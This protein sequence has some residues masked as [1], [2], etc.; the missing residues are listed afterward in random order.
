MKIRNK[1]LGVIIMLVTSLC[2][3]SAQEVSVGIKFLSAT[4]E[5]EEYFD[6]PVQ[7]T[8]GTWHAIEKI[9]SEITLS[10]SDNKYSLVKYSLVL[11]RGTTTEQS[12][13]EQTNPKIELKGL[14]KSG[15]YTVELSNVVLSY[16]DKDTT[17]EVTLYDEE[18]FQV[19]N[20]KLELYDAP[21]ISEENISELSKEVVWNTTKRDFSVTANDGNESGWKYVWYIDG[22]KQSVTNNEWSGTFSVNNSKPQVFKVEVINMAPD[23][24]T[25]WYHNEYERE[26]TVYQI[27]TAEL[28][29][30]GS[31]CPQTMDWYCEDKNVGSISVRT[32]G[33]SS[34]WDYKWKYNGRDYSGETFK[35]TLANSAIS[36]GY[37]SPYEYTLVLANKPEGMSDVLVKEGE[38]ELKGSIR[39]WKTPKVEFDNTEYK[40]VF[41]GK[42]VKMT[43]NS[44][45][46]Y[47]NGW[48]I[49][50][51]DINLSVNNNTYTFKATDVNQTSEDKQFTIKYTNTLQGSYSS[52]SGTTDITVKIWN[53]PRIE[54]YYMS[55]NSEISGDRK[56]PKGNNVY[57]NSGFGGTVKLGVMLRDG[58]NDSWTYSWKKDQQNYDESESECE[59]N[60]TGIAK[61]EYSITVTNKPEGVK[62]AFTATQTF[63]LN[64]LESPSYHLNS[65]SNVYA[66]MAGRALKPSFGINGGYSD[67]W[68]Y[69][70]YDEDG[71][72]ISRDMSASIRVPDD[73]ETIT[74]INYDVNVSNFGPEGDVWFDGS[75]DDNKMRIRVNAYPLPER[76]GNVK[77]I[78][79]E[80]ERLDAYYGS[81]QY[82]VSFDE[83]IYKDIVSTAIVEWNY[84]VSYNDITVSNSQEYNIEIPQSDAEHTYTNVKM[85]AECK[86]TDEETGTELT[87][88]DETQSLHFHSWSKGT[89]NQ[90]SYPKHI[91]F[92]ETVE[93]N[94]NTVGGYDGGITGEGESTTAGGWKFTWL[95]EDKKVIQSENNNYYLYANKYEYGNPKSTSYYLCCE[96]TLGGEVGYSDTLVYTFN[97]YSKPI[98]ATVYGSYDK[99][100]RQNDEYTLKASVPGGAN[101]NGWQYSWNNRDWYDI[102][103]EVVIEEVFSAT[104]SSGSVPYNENQT[105]TFYYRNVAPDDPSKVWSSNVVTYNVTVYRRP[106]EPNF[107]KKGSGSSH[108]YIAII[109][110]GQRV[111]EAGYNHYEFEYGQQKN[112]VFV[113]NTLTDNM[114]YRYPGTANPTNPYVRSLWRYDNFDCYSDYVVYGSGTRA[115]IKDLTIEDGYFYATLEEESPALLTVY[116]L[117]GKI[118]KQISYPANTQFSEKIDLGNLNSGIYMVKC[119]VSDQQVVKKIMVQ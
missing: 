64:V 37:S 38:N 6:I 118:V 60:V 85:N 82:S 66:E 108:I 107:T 28:M 25:E 1:I 8:D 49:A 77:F 80:K 113:A 30:N 45:G 114:Y 35:P 106:A 19:A 115:E 51:D 46:G 119:N 99:Q 7:S 27:P 70:W 10:A 54:M 5:S 56:Q 53:T 116:S 94:S 92:G 59:I 24:K 78:G 84:S 23:G 81:T 68:Q 112:G 74:A 88:Y 101:V 103:D 47:S 48:S 3:I 16:K 111:G 41:E 18:S 93:L 32:N 42:D 40:A 89:I 61:S 2:C 104:I 52:I 31:L 97:Y 15:T 100:L 95:D 69:V 65:G 63:I 76:V 87:A 36:N 26:F 109:V 75:S 4:G 72:E 9:N 83:G 44:E 29:Y 17:K 105:M 110:G 62:E 58:K 67:G 13:T 71:N 11:K 43:F 12:L 50:I 34:N 86:V 102:T 90:V 98:D 79:F 57:I 21:E 55:N 117:E 14:N 73:I 33:G 96:N 22:S 39:F 20:F 91:Q